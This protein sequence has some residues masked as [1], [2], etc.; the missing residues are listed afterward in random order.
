[1]VERRKLLGNSGLDYLRSYA[2]YLLIA[3][4]SN[5]MGTNRFNLRTVRDFTIDFINKNYG[6]IKKRTYFNDDETE[7]FLTLDD[8]IIQ[9][10]L[11]LIIEKEKS[12][13]S[14]NVAFLLEKVL[15]NSSRYAEINNLR[16]YCVKNELSY[17]IMVYSRQNVTDSYLVFL[18]GCTNRFIPQFYNDENINNFKSNLNKM[19]F[20]NSNDDII[21][22][23]QMS[24]YHLTIYSDYNCGIQGTIRFDTNL[25]PIIPKDNIK[26]DITLE[27]DDWYGMKT[28]NSIEIIESYAPYG[29]TEESD[30]IKRLFYES[31][32]NEFVDLE[33]YHENYHS[34]MK[35]IVLSVKLDEIDLLLN[36]K[37]PKRDIYIPDGT[38]DNF[39]TGLYMHRTYYPPM[40]YLYN[41]GNECKE[42]TGYYGNNNELLSSGINAEKYTGQ[43]INTLDSISIKANNEENEDNAIVSFKSKNMLPFRE[44]CFLGIDYK[45][46]SAGYTPEED[47]GNYQLSLSNSL[48]DLKSNLFSITN[49]INVGIDRNV[50]T[51][52]FPYKWRSEDN[53]FIDL[54]DRIMKTT[55]NHLQSIYFISPYNELQNGNIP[56]MIFKA[57]IF[58]SWSS[59]RSWRGTVLYLCQ[60]TEDYKYP[61]LDKD[62]MRY[63]F[64]KVINSE[65]NNINNVNHYINKTSYGGFYS[66]D[67]YSNKG[68]VLAN[69][70]NDAIREV[71]FPESCYMT[72][73]YDNPLSAFELVEIYAPHGIYLK[74]SLYT[75]IPFD[76]LLNIKYLIGKSN[77]LYNSKVNIYKIYLATMD[78]GLK[79]YVFKEGDQ[80]EGTTGGWDNYYKDTHS[81]WRINYKGE[82]LNNQIILDFSDKNMSSEGTL[83]SL[84]SNQKIDISKFESISVVYSATT[85]NTVTSSGCY[86]T[87]KL[88]EKLQ[89]SEI[90]VGGIPVF[91]PPNTGNLETFKS[92]TSSFNIGEKK[93]CYILPIIISE[94]GYT[95]TVKIKE[96]YLTKKKLI[97]NDVTF[98]K[99]FPCVITSTTDDIKITVDALS[100]LGSKLWYKYEIIDS[101]NDITILKDF[102]INNICSWIPS[103]SDTYTVK[104]TIK[105]IYGNEI[106]KNYTNNIIH[107]HPNSVAIFNNGIVNT[108]LTGGF[109]KQYIDT[110]WYWSSSNCGNSKGEII[111]NRLVLN[112]KTYGR[113]CY[114]VS[115]GTTNKIDL[116]PYSSLC[117]IYNG[118]MGGSRKFR[119]GLATGYS[120]SEL[121]CVGGTLIPFNDLENND[122]GSIAY[123]VSI[124][125]INEERYIL[126]IILDDG[127]IYTGQYIKIHS[128]ILIKKNIEIQSF[129]ANVSGSISAN[130]SITF[131]A[132][133]KRRNAI[134]Y[135]IDAYDDSGTLIENC[136]SGI[137][138]ASDLTTSLWG[139]NTEIGSYTIKNPNNYT[140]VFTVTDN[141]TNEKVIKKIT[142]IKVEGIISVSFAQTEN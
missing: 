63:T 77:E 104:I 71:F 120:G 100:N 38:L 53:D 61:Y 37:D 8:V 55:D 30:K 23:K 99:D 9:K 32:M 122:T 4:L 93:D 90:S 74:D 42:I 46:E 56:Y 107:Y 60:G 64:C 22:E 87:I 68:D 40:L 102:N 41:K 139:D 31:Y 117:V 24:S 73:D 118:K 140:F 43:A 115:L 89:S 109:T 95:G 85:G 26:Y 86:F 135:S 88:A 11:D 33:H 136:I 105:D 62:N 119:I 132:I 57:D 84:A 65:N 133:V 103:K 13:K 47:A 137:I 17:M 97:I 121:G 72:K 126:P 18:V 20:Y 76:N 49:N 54:F 34:D 50:N 141:V 35:P 110:H 83:I 78:E 16:T 142:G 127:S 69:N 5:V 48:G 58:W 91:I 130:T 134:S 114:I 1:M 51:F 116:S 113:Y 98:S 14:D 25:T 15:T 82:I 28:L 10:Y 111:D 67:S 2:G 27:T 96:I 7:L 36:W 6:L 112:H 129:A 79:Q 70:D 92:Y 3:G 125:N 12:I 52:L 66:E 21:Y 45:I 59:S 106:S 29:F 128:I 138:G 108:E 75:H 39:P 131:N 81:Y 80:W 44:Y 101:N 94:R 19:S 124:G 123:D